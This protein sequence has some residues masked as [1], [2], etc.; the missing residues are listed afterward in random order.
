M[1]CRLGELHGLR[2]EAR[3]IRYYEREHLLAR[4]AAYQM[5]INRLYSL[6]HVECEF[7]FIASS[8]AP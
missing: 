1:R 8:A 6:Q 4:A 7:A 5:A 3:N 2:C